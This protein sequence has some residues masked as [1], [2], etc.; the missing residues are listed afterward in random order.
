[1]T[2][3]HEPDHAP[4]R[5]DL[6]VARVRRARR[7]RLFAGGATVVA[8]LA[9]AGVAAASTPQHSDAAASAPSASPSLAATTARGDLAASR[10]LEAGRTPLVTAPV[11]AVRATASTPLP[12]TAD[13]R[14]VATSW[15]QNEVVKAPATV[16]ALLAAKGVHADSDDRITVAPVSAPDAHA[17]VA[18]KVDVQRVTVRNVTT[19]TPV[20]H[21]TVTKTEASRYATL[22]TAVQKRGKDGVKT[23]VQR[24]T[25]V[26]GAVTARKTVSAK[27]TAAVTTVLVKGTKK[28]PA[29][30]VAK[31]SAG[32]T[33]SGAQAIGRS[34]AAKRGWGA[35]QFQ[36][37]VTLWNR[38]SGWRV[39]A[40]NGSSGAYGI[41]QSLP[42]SKMASAGADWRTSATTQITWGLNYI[43]GSYGSPCG[44][45]SHSYANGWY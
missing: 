44:A 13:V 24:V 3:S 32:A 14:L 31:S 27:S 5:H 18:M 19:R 45:L 34:L 8:A 37:L 23:V 7:H 2:F 20:H 25:T 12:A 6:R 41:P 26:D 17:G 38:E 42:G 22:G 9:L 21:K 40:A 43:A 35:D 1:M 36:C 10:G 11:A 39:N 16:G 28:H 15:K 4:T 29:K 30:T 33:P